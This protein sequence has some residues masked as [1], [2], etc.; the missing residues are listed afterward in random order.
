VFALSPYY[1][2]YSNGGTVKDERDRL[3]KE[4]LA[5]SFVTKNLFCPQ[6]SPKTGHL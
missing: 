2:G 1:L 5:A 4:L 3:Y 6:R